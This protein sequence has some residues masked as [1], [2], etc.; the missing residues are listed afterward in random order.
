MLATWLRALAISVAALSLA[1]SA[2]AAETHPCASVVDPNERLAC[3]DAA[4][5]PVANA[6]A[7]ETA[8]ARRARQE[9]EFGL[10]GTQKIARTPEAE[11]EALP[12]RIEAAVTTIYSSPTGERIVTLDNGQLWMLTEVSS[13]GRLKSG[14]KVVVRK[15]AMGSFMLVTPSRIALRA[16]RIQ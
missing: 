4:F 10:S 8:E 12:D 14:D 15:A 11:R 2:I 7:A 1:G 5:P 13:T 16:K 6:R 9:R 3:Y